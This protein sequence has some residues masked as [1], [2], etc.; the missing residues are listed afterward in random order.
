MS[1]TPEHPKVSVL[2]SVYNM[3]TYLRSCLDGIIHQTLEDIEIICVD[4]ASTDNS[5]S[6]LQE[7]AAKDPRITV[8]SQEHSGAGTARNTALKLA[9][10]KYLSILDADDL[11]DPK[12]LEHAYQAAER[13]EAQ[14]VVFRTDFYNDITHCFEPC[15]YSIKPEMLPAANPFS[16][17]DLAD[18]IFNVGCGWAWDKLFSRSFVEDCNIFFQEIRTTNDMLFVFYLYSRAE[19]IYYLSNLLVHHRINVKR[20]LSVT[21]EQSWNNFYLALRA[22]QERLQQDGSYELFRHS[23]VNWALNFSL[24]HIDTISSLIRRKLINKCRDEYFSALDI[25]GHDKDYYIDSFEYERMTKI[26]NSSGNVKVSVIIP[27]YNGG[28]YLKQCL[29]SICAQTLQDIQIICVDDASTDDTPEILHIYESRD[30]R[31]MVFRKEEHTNAGDSR[32]TG[33]MLAEGEY[34]SFLDADDFFEPTLL[35]H[36][37]NAAV[38]DSAE[39]VSF[40]CNQYDDRNGGFRDCPWTLKLHEMPEKR[41]FSNHDCADRIFTMTSCTAWDKLFKREFVLN[42]S[43]FFQDLPSCNDMVFTFSA[44]SVASSITTLDEILVHQRVGQVK[45]YA[46]DIEYL[47]HNF[48]DALMGLKNFLTERE[49]YPTFKKSFVNWAIDF[50]IWNM[51]NYQDYFRDLIRQSLKNKFFEDLDISTAPQEDFFNQNLYREMS[52]IMAEKKPYDPTITPKVSILIPTYNVEQYMRIC[53]DSAVNQTLEE[54]EIIVINDGSTDH[55]LD[56]IEE[57][58]AKDPR[59]KIIDKEN[60]GYGMAMNKGL[61]LATGEYIGII[62]PDDFVDLHMFG[63]LYQI[64]AKDNL[65]FVKSDFNRFTHD[66]YGD[67]VFHYNKIAK[68]DENYNKIIK[69]IDFQESFKFVMNTWSGI[70]NRQFLLDHNIRHNETPGA[71]FQDN[72]FWFQTMMYAER[73]MF[74]NKPY[75]LNRRDNPNSS[76]AS[77]EKVYCMNNE[78][79]YIRDILKKDPEKASKLMGQLHLKKYHNYLFRYDFIAQ[80]Y[81]E[82]YLCKM[83]EEFAE[84]RNKGELDETLFTNAELENLNWIIND[85]HGYYEF[86]NSSTPQVSVIIPVYNTAPMLRQCLDTVLSQT[87]KNIEVICVDDGSDDASMDIL[88]EYESSDS[89]VKILQQ[90]NA[91][92]GVARNKGIDIAKGK[93]LSFLDSDDFFELKMLEEAYKKCERTGA[94]ICVYQVKRYDNN[95]G[96]SWFDK[97]SFVEANF[98]SKRSGI[99]VFSAKDLGSHVF[100]TFMTWPWNKLFKRRFVMENGL[101]FQEIFRTNDLYFVNTALLKARYITTVR[102]PLVNYRVG[103]TNNCQ[104]TN[105]KAPTDFHKALVALYEEVQKVS[106]QDNLISFYNLYVRSCNYNLSSLFD[107]DPEAYA[108]LYRYLHEDGFDILD[109]TT[110]PEKCITKDNNLAYKECCQV[111][112]NSFEKYIVDKLS[113]NRNVV[114]ADSEKLKKL[115]EENDNLKKE[116]KKIKEAFKLISSLMK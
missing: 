72:G 62:E 9:K 113:Y 24:W 39:I 68:N 99:E 26:M 82:E 94:E 89:R 6:I 79:V 42:Q 96:K 100:N 55:C 14:I 25:V 46:K 69:P 59:I 66:E 64:A 43:L 5:L 49:L 107:T 67:L 56:I 17:R 81:Q 50:S 38:A 70:Y 84:A 76:V 34:L 29:D 112:K 115:K 106:N 12:M 61:D 15:D 40:R 98:P 2:L 48:Y 45:Y 93:Y 35:E 41:P 87:L 21:R 77:R 11:F 30:D 23:F 80:E 36:A 44:Y 108:F 8:V 75:Y 60:G 65:D 105:N 4:D 7:Y 91:G 73:A 109:P 95:T 22:L 114:K 10:G 85:P 53:L 47:W 31:I 52:D 97:G 57:Y 3:E 19:R 92:G 90:A 33:L 16:S 71:S 13:T 54:I 111:R 110:I 18:R 83:S 116:S 28:R 32:N 88:R 1:N 101:R 20:S 58:A 37:Y 78:Y 51:H 104:A 86:N 102:I 103:T 63:D 27:I 74:C